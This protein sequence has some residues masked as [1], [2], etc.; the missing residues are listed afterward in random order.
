MI[1]PR[2]LRSLSIIFAIAFAASIAGTGFAVHHF[3][4]IAIRDVVDRRIADVSHA[5]AGDSVDPAAILRRMQALSTQRDTGDIGI[6][7]DDAQGRRLGGNIALTE[8]PPPGLSTLTVNAGIKGLSEGRALV[9]TVGDGLRLTTVAETEPFDHYNSDR[10]YI[11]FLGF[12]SIV[13]VVSAGTAVF[14]ILVHRRILEIRRTADAIV[15]GDMRKRVP[16]RGSGGTFDQQALAF[17]RML[18]RISELMAGIS[19]VSNDVAHDLRTPLS[20]LR[21]RLNGLARTAA[22]EAERERIEVARDQCD[23]MLAMFAAVLRIA[24]VQ[25][26]ARRAAFARL[27]LGALTEEIGTMMQPVVVDSGREMLLGPFE[28]LPIEGDR[29]LLSQALINLI[30][31][32]IRYTPVAS[33]ITVAAKRMP[34]GAALIVGDNGPGIAE[35]DRERA[36]RR[37]GRLDESRNTSGYG[38]GLPLVQAIARLHRGRLILGDA[39]P[40]LRVEL[41]VPSP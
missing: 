14:G 27:D 1:L 35:A 39:H 9:R 23:Q 41:V 38:L 3:T 40:G 12:G 20:R 15:D 19:N 8:P 24:E 31:N 36:L 29:Q 13:L 26:G 37:F 30:E 22:S 7:L 33:T 2:R 4:R 10:F 11:Y 5:A 21:A 17:N 32:A 6:Q 34:Q 18:D 16:V 28:P 25:G